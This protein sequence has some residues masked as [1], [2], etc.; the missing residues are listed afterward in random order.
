M[1]ASDI[2]I[3]GA[4][5]HNLQ[6]VNL[7]LP[8]NRLICFTGVSG[9]GKSSLAFDT[10]YAE[11]QRRYV[12]SLSTFARQ[13]IG[14][15]A[16]PNVDR[17]DGLSPSICIS[18]KTAGSNPRSTVGT[19]TEIYDYLRILY[20]RTGTCYCPQCGGAI[21]AQ[22]RDKI[23][24]Q[25]LQTAA[26]QTVYVLAPL[27]R[28]QK[29]EHR[30]LFAGLLRQGFTRARIDGQI[31]RLEED[32]KL[33]RHIRHD[34]EVV[35]DRLT[36]SPAQ[37]SRLAEAVENA[38][39]LSNGEVLLCAEEGSPRRGSGDAESVPSGSSKSPGIIGYFSS[40]YA[41]PKCQIPFPPPSPQM[42]SFNSPEGMCPS[43]Q[44]LGSTTQ[45]DIVS[46]LT[47][48]GRSI[49]QGCFGVLGKWRELPFR[50][51]AALN[52]YA[53][54]LEKHFGLEGGSI[55]E[56]AWEEL[57]P[58]VQKA[59][60]YGVDRNT[61]DS[62]TKTDYVR[63]FGPFQGLT[64]IFDLLMN[65]GLLPTESQRVLSQAYREGPCPACGGARLRVEARSVKLR[66]A[67]PDF[68]DHPEKSLPEV[69]AL[70]ISEA[71][72]FFGELVLDEV[73]QKI[74]E[75]PL[76][77]IRNRLEFLSNVGLDYLT[78]DRS[79]PSL[80]GGE[81]QRIR[82]AGQIGSGLVGVTY[83]LDEP[84]IGLH[85]RDNDRL[86]ATLARLRDQGNTVVV[87]EHDEDTMRAA[88][89]IVD[90]GPGPGTRG[91][92]IVAIGDC[93]DIMKVPESVTGQYLSG[94]R[95]IPVPARRR[96]P[97]DKK[98]VVRGARHNNLKNIDVEIPLGL[99]VCVT[100]V[101]G[102]GKSS[103]VSDI[104][105]EALNRE[106]NGGV[107]NPGKFDRIEGLQHLDKM[108]AIDQSPI[109]RTPRSNPATYIKVFD[110]IRK[111]FADLPESR[112]RGY[113]PGRFSFNVE[114]GR[115]EA[116][117]GNGATKL[118]MDFLADIWV[119]CPVCEGRRFNRQTLQVRYKGKTIADVLEMEVREALRLFENIPPIRH[120][121]ETLQAVGL[122]YM[123]LG[124]PSPTLSGGEAQ[125]VKLARELTKRSTGR[126]IYFLDE[127]T[128]GLHFADIEM[129]LKVLHS[130][131]DAGNTV[132]VVE[133]NLEVI[134]TADWII[135]LGPEGGEA[136]GYVVAVGTPEEVAQN[137]NSHTGR[138]LRHVLAGHTL[139]KANGDS[140]D[141][142]A[143]FRS[144]KARTRKAKPIRAVSIRGARQHNLKGINVDIPRDKLTVCC[145]RSGSGKSSLAMDT[146]YA[147]GQRRYVESLSTYARQFVSQMQKPK[148]DHVEG[149]SPAIAIEQKH[150]A[151]TPR[152]TVGT[153]TEIYD[154]F[155][156]LMARLGQ[157]YCPLCGIPVGTQAAD[158]IIAKVMDHPEGTRLFLLA[159]IDLRDG[160]DIGQLW[161]ELRRQGFA[162]VRVDGV[163]HSL[164]E[165][166]H[167]DRRRQ[168]TV[169]V[170]VDRVIVRPAERDR[171]AGSVE[172]ALSIGEGVLIVLYPDERTAE[173]FWKTVKHSQHFACQRCGRSF[174]PLS[175]NHFSFNSPLGW[176]PG[177]QGLGKEVGADPALLV[178]DPHATLQEQALAIWP[179]MDEPLARAMIEALCRETGIPLDVPWEELSGIARR[180]IFHGTGDRWFDVY[181]EDYERLRRRLR[182][183]SSAESAES[184]SDRAERRV[185]LRFQYKG[186][187]PA[188]AAATAASPRLRAALQHVVEEG[189]CTLCGG[190]RL[191]D[192]AAAV[193]FRNRTI[194]EWCRL[195]LGRL[196]EEVRNWKLDPREQEIAG[197]IVREIANRVQFLVD[198]GLD[199]LTLA[200]AAPTLS[201]GESQRIR[202]AAQVGS[203]L[204]GVLYVL[205]EPTI[206][207]HPRDNGRL[208]AA[209]KKLRDLGNTLLVVEHDREVI[210]AADH[211]LDFGPD[212]GRKGGEI[213]A[214]GPPSRVARS[215][216][217]VTGPYLTGRKAI[218]VPAKRRMPSWWS[219][220][221]M[222]GSDVQA[223]GVPGQHVWR[224]F[225]P[226]ACGWLE[227]CG[228]RHNNLKNID[229]AIPLG[230]LTVVTGVS[231]SGKSSLVEDVLYN[232]LAA[233]L[234]R[235]NT[236]PGDFDELRG[237]EFINKVIRVDQQPLGQ[238]P[239]ST[240]ATYT[241]VF[242]KIR[243]LFA[244]LP[245]AKRR[246]FTR[247]RFSF[248]VPGGRCEKCE[249]AGRI[250][251]EMH[252]LPDVWVECD[253]C[254]GRRYDAETL[255]VTYHGKSI[256][257]VL[258]MPCEEALELFK[259]IPDI[260]R[261][262]EVLCDVGLG[263]LQLGQPANTLSGGE[264]Q[265]VK[266]AAELARPDTGR[267]LYLL[268]E[269][270]TGLHFDDLAKLLDVLQ[271]LVD[272]GNT[273]VV[274]EHN[275]EVIKSAD[276]V[277]DLGPEAG[278]GG[279]HVVV[280]GT[281]EDIVAYAR[282]W[283]H[284][285]VGSPPGHGGGN[286]A[287]GRAVG[288]VVGPPWR[289]YTGEVLAPVL[290]SSPRM[291]Y[292][293]Y[294]REQ[295]AEQDL[296]EVV[297]SLT[298]TDTRHPW[299]TDG[300]SWHLSR[301]VASN[302]RPIRWDRT[303]LEKIVG[304]LE[305]GPSPM[306]VDW[307]SQNVVE[308]RPQKSSP[309]WFVHLYTGD[310]DQLRIK[311]RTGKR[312]SKTWD[313]FDLLRKPRAQKAPPV[314]SP[315]LKLYV[316]P[317]EQAQ[318]ESPLPRATIAS[319]FQREWWEIDVRVSELASIDHARFWCFLDEAKE[320]FL[321]V[322]QSREATTPRY[323]FAWHFSQ[324][325][326]EGR[327]R[328]SPSL[329]LKLKNVIA[330]AAPQA[331]ESSNNARMIT[332]R[333]GEKKEIWAVVY[334]KRAEELALAVRVPKGRFA[335]GAL[336]KI[337]DSVEIDGSRRNEDRL[338]MA[339]TGSELPH[340]EALE[341]LLREAARE[342]LASLAEKN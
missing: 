249:G 60:L 38:I 143:F 72:K 330:K 73:G 203:G 81:M 218:P 18:Q 336:L 210:Q 283:Q 78:L 82:L 273:V 281:P 67:H 1:A 11:G 63:Q 54:W 117:E 307:R 339:W 104:L 53:E 271:R 131:V 127:P 105:V 13:F 113:K 311:L 236:T 232:A 36:V 196:L 50:L 57:P 256:S 313:I 89:C 243:D 185:L 59:L 240:P 23:V 163:I 156:V 341:E 294:R 325:G 64:T 302:G 213:V 242:E 229:V 158:Q 217:S 176:C 169:E 315:F 265:R 247:R 121:L 321:K 269:P 49:Q 19:I 153:V 326:I 134:K 84:S 114:G 190:S 164:D 306:F 66:T 178:L 62:Q 123:K 333:L 252:F 304:H 182:G 228:A 237:V 7:V 102:S 192:D 90:F 338:I 208:L 43:C 189:D 157:P 187:Y 275:L 136:G 172:T 246:G 342:F 195:P 220:E 230:T 108:I 147:E 181:V 206:G 37:R 95:A 71:R 93:Q 174:E 41:C 47:D 331:A 120:K 133:H 48:S 56:T 141:R 234:H 301:E 139:P 198:V 17:I 92:H 292:K 130:F 44:G 224:K 253:A 116:C 14:Q 76:K 150:A 170:V 61:L 51:R 188:L 194:D 148:V 40:R 135:D 270:T 39:N 337:C 180:I 276:W 288:Q 98:L 216:K 200:R 231:G 223:G 297:R 75:E 140:Q 267:T 324:S 29:G 77:E 319:S 235:A 32:L 277:I 167:I 87:V 27:I 272:L 255:A 33:R 159:P 285:R 244:E 83:I 24:E 299:E 184:P 100:G 65:E 166:P 70:P 310:D 316:P 112:M 22:P 99:F 161:D 305:G 162:R 317:Q 282:W 129:L 226:P 68:A 193:R 144:L 145:G 298:G 119:T 171:I 137:E 10:L 9:S 55:L 266:L 52:K 154:Y 31:V 291:E 155:R 239:T 124:Q 177:C 221:V 85:P 323:D 205:D 175:P 248:N 227:V 312:L 132:V 241:G 149:L 183:G 97:T 329:L 86:L 94:K 257:D 260:R 287:G 264:A 125:R 238:T 111:L 204:C 296:Q 199:Y 152:S 173:P 96:P 186:L 28:G 45:L 222:R 34:I 293:P 214:Q 21:Q 250:K 202:L 35:V 322:A 332:W 168:H 8:R 335:R 146:V 280:A 16:K 42:F 103:L 268:D 122:D 261:I 212:A 5:E 101:S 58:T 254:H 46:L 207:L 138:F 118:E 6:G 263:Y 327:P 191:R 318:D 300:R 126:T 26:G 80:S 314:V 151:N 3:Q 309:V 233:E 279:G 160:A 79:A 197:D 128:T 211:L 320:E 308:V 274:I 201:G 303:I 2:V 334:T 12:E 290:E 262:L 165:P 74:A 278:D 215:A 15:M 328:W 245:E 106:L 115:C 110:D 289:S 286:N 295:E 142:E 4:R 251:I 259:N 69:C 88:D 91:G 109:G 20:A 25:I 219:E 30:N 107:G 340:A 209:L 179:K 258:D 225:R 284:G